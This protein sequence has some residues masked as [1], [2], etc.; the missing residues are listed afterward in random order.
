MVTATALQEA[1]KFEEEGVKLYTELLNKS[2]DELMKRLFQ[3]LVDQEKE[4][5]SYINDFAKDKKF[6]ELEYTPLESIMKNIYEATKKEG[7][8]KGQMNNVEGYELALELEDKGYKM[9]QKAFGSAASE[10][11]KKFFKFLMDMEQEHYEA[12]ANIYNFM[13]DNAKWL[14]ENES[15]TWNWM[16]L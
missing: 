16:N 11:E 5:I 2:S 10:E 14:A 12:L 15:T 3:S 4:H 9:Y 1:I 8:Q 6:K 13:T 7:Q